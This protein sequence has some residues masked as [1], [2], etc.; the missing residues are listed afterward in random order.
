MNHRPS[1]IRA[2]LTAAALAIAWVLLRPPAAAHAGAVTTGDVLH[3]VERGE[4][5]SSIAVRYGVNMSAIMQVNAILDADR[6]YIGQRLTIPSASQGTVFTSGGCGE[7]YTVRLGDYLS[8]IAEQYGVTVAGIQ[9]ANGLWGSLIFPGMRLAI[10]CG[11]TSQTP[12]TSPSAGPTLS[13]PLSNGKY[14]IRPGDGLLA[15]ALRCG[16]SV[17]ALRQANGLTSD[18]IYAGQWLT[19]GSYYVSSARPEVAVASTP[20]TQAPPPVEAPPQATPPPERVIIRVLTLPPT[21]TP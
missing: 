11:W 20:A 10:P 5:L 6:I 12:W 14:L 18:L 3:I 16:T 9:E 21:P 15:I 7:I 19:I 17:A 2:L 1:M 13:C 4:N 8:K